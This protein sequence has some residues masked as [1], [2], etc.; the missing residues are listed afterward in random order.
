VEANYLFSLKTDSAN[1]RRNASL[2]RNMLTEYLK[3]E[4][5]KSENK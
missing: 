4:I 5:L 1:A 3:G 2:Q